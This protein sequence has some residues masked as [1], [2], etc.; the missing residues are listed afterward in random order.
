MKLCEPVILGHAH[1]KNK[2]LHA[3]TSKIVGFSGNA[4]PAQF[5]SQ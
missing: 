5:K 4:T 2:G 3:T 1:S